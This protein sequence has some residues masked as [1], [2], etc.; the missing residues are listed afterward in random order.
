MTRPEIHAANSAL[1]PR[2]LTRQQAIHY[3]GVKP[4]FFDARIRPH[5]RCARAGT[6]MLFDRADLDRAIEALFNSQQPEPAQDAAPVGHPEDEQKTRG[7]KPWE[8]RQ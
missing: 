3:V 6:T 1:Q 4:S 8:K 5:V 2:C 7:L